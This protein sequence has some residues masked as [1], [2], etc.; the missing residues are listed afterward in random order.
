M[1]PTFGKVAHPK[2]VYDRIQLFPIEVRTYPS[3]FVAEII[4]NDEEITEA[5][6]ALM[7]YIGFYGDPH[8][9]KGKT[10]YKMS[11]HGLFFHLIISSY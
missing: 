4:C 8:N 11:P 2:A 6:Q 10:S 1:G 7:D 3:T 9:M 5:S